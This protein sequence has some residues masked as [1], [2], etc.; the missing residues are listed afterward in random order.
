MVD[1]PKG[2]DAEPEVQAKIAALVAELII[3]EPRMSYRSRALLGAIARWAAEL[4][5]PAAAQPPP[6]ANG[7]RKT[8]AAQPSLPGA[9]GAE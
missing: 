9:G 4:P 8:N 7:R 2:L 3:L 1:T 6:T 5:A